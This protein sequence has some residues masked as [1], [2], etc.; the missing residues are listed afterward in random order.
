M[1]P[2]ECPA[3]GALALVER[4]SFLPIHAQKEPEFPLPD[5]MRSSSVSF[6]PYVISAKDPL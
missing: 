6:F 5:V 2:P 4:N 3:A 1:Y